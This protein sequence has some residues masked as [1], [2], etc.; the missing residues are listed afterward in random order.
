MVVV[1]DTIYH[2]EPENIKGMSASQRS[3]KFQAQFKY[4]KA[5]LFSFWLLV[6]KMVTFCKK[7]AVLPSQH[8]RKK[9]LNCHKGQTSTAVGLKMYLSE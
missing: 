9:C 2:K 8:G 3:G 4:I 7:K 6:V 1:K 5:I